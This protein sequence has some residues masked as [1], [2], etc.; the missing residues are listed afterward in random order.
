MSFSVKIS[1][2]TEVMVKKFRWPMTVEAG[3]TVREKVEREC[4]KTFL[5]NGGFVTDLDGVGVETFS[6]DG[7]YLFINFQ[8]QGEI[9]LFPNSRN[10]Q[11]PH[12]TLTFSQ[13][14]LLCASTCIPFKPDSN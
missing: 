7:E 10:S 13:F 9:F 6:E 5:V 11:L 12:N 14:H 4:R 8:V 3:V 2:G 1:K